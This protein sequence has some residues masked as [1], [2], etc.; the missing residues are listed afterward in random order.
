MNRTTQTALIGILSSIL[1]QTRISTVHAQYTYKPLD[2]LDRIETVPHE[3]LALRSRNFRTI[4]R[5]CALEEKD[6]LAAVNREHAELYPGSPNASIAY[7]AAMVL[8]PVMFDLAEELESIIGDTGTMDEKIARMFAWAQERM[9]HTQMTGIF[10]D[11]P[12]YDPWGEREDQTGA[13]YKKLL[14]SE[15]LAMTMHTGKVSGK[16]ITLA[17]LIASLFLRLGVPPEDI[18][19]VITMTPGG[20]RHGGALIEYDGSILLVN[21][22]AVGPFILEPFR[23]ATPVQVLSVYNH[24]DFKEAS[25]PLTADSIDKAFWEDD[26]SLMDRFLIAYG[27][28][29]LQETFGKDFDLPLDDIGA[30]HRTVFENKQR[31]PMADLVK[32]AYQSLYVQHPEMYLKASLRISHPRVLAGT[33][34]APEAAFD[35]IRDHIRRGSIFPDGGE[36]LMTADQVMVFQQGSLKD[37]AVL[38]AAILFH[39]G[40]RPEVWIGRRG[41]YVHFDGR[42]IDVSDWKDAGKVSEKILIR[43]R[44]G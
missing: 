6:I 11:W 10:K 25:F 37:Q 17:N 20:Y 4:H 5:E 36:R 40:L 27:R 41:V 38:A 30:L 2:Q 42:T 18:V 21:N 23:G 28:V 26:R 7:L 43:L 35:W 33:L 9:C 44:T 12:G 24:M 22:N 34:D 29:E 19:L 3:E 14:P 32:Y 1:I 13:T 8:D 15:M 16:C 39:M 31:T